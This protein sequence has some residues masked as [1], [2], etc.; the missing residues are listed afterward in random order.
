MAAVGE[1]VLAGLDEDLLEYVAGLCEDTDDA[2]DHADASAT[3]PATL[4]AL[5]AISL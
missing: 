3:K 4:I 1:R 2:G 5:V